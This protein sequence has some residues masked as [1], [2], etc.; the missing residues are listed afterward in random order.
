MIEQDF[1]TFTDN[2]F[3]NIG[4]GINAMQDRVPELAQ[5]FLRAKQQGA[6]VDVA[7]LTDKD[8]SDLGRFAVDEQLDSMGAFKTSTLRNIAV[9][10]PF[11]HDGS[12]AT[13]REVVEHYNN[14]GATTPEERI[15]PFLSGGIR[16]LDLTDQQID[17]LV[18]FMEALTSPQFAEL[19]QVD[20]SQPTASNTGGAQ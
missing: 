13:L 4:V 14:G 18:A 5:A 20:E 19:A 12:I 16:P 6:D 17:D 3:H 1:A 11:M 10:G 8:T 7:V 15:N 2:Q 9:T